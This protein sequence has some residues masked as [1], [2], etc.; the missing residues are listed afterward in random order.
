MKEE[1]K[2]LE[3]RMAKVV[4]FFETRDEMNAWMHMGMIRYSPLT[5]EARSIQD[6]LTRLSRES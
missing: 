4:R 2:K 1:L 5:V 3:E 6:E